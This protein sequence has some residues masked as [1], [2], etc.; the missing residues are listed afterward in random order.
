MLRRN[1][2]FIA[3]L[4]ITL[5]MLGFG[6]VRSSHWPS[7]SNDAMDSI[8]LE[9]AIRVEGCPLPHSVLSILGSIL[10]R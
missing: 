8:R 2:D 10:H 6:W 9:N 3:V 7:W 5:V 4:L 1:V